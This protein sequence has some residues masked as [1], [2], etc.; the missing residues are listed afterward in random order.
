MQDASELAYMFYS[1]P[2]VLQCLR[3]IEATVLTRAVLVRMGARAAAKAFERHVQT[4]Y[5]PF[6]RAAIRHMFACG[7]VAW[8][9]RKTQEGDAVPEA[10]PL[11]SFRWGVRPPAKRGGAKLLEYYITHC[12][13]SVDVKDIFIF[14]FT[15]PMYYGAMQAKMTMSPFAIALENH[16]NY[17]LACQNAMEADKWNA[18]PQ[19]VYTNKPKQQQSNVATGIDWIVDHNNCCDGI[20]S[21]TRNKNDIVRLQRLIGAM[22]AQNIDTSSINIYPVTDDSEV[23]QLQAVQP[24][25]TIDMMLSIYKES[26]CNIMGIPSQLI[27]RS[28]KIDTSRESA[29]ASGYTTNSRLFSNS[30]ANI[31]KQMSL[32]LDTVYFEAYK[33]NAT[34]IISPITRLEVQT[35][36]TIQKLMEK[37]NILAPETKTLVQ[38]DLHYQISGETL[39]RY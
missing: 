6:C 36:E 34:F 13:C 14:E 27:M 3:L 1:D 28:S 31:A 12:Y 32:L 2:F 15:P 21:S 18:R 39:K 19:L 20:S 5:I 38:Q 17:M 4:H 37:D 10:V 33:Q 22:E 24:K 7:F 23:T 16:R 30:M 9:M 29:N 25:V 8:R 26:V 11:G 35:Y